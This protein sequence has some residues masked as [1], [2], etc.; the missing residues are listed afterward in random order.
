MAEGAGTG[1]RSRRVALAQA[2]GSPGWAAAAVGAGAC[3][4]VE[5]AALLG[6]LDG[7]GAGRLPAVALAKFAPLGAGWGHA[8]ARIAARR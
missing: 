4:A 6:V 8:A 3:G 7:R 5:N 1:H 2:L